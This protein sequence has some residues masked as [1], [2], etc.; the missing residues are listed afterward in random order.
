MEGH[1]KN[2]CAKYSLIPHQPRMNAHIVNSV[3]F[4]LILTSLSDIVVVLSCLLVTIKC[5][6]E[7][8]IEMEQKIESLTDVINDC[9]LWHQLE[10]ALLGINTRI[11][12]LQRAALR[13][14][15]TPGSAPGSAFQ[16]PSLGES[17][18]QEETEEAEVTLVEAAIQTS[19]GGVSY[20]IFK[21]TY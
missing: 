13:A 12:S 14:S 11:D 16:Q 8:Q 5:L 9:V 2:W 17:G 3:A 6:L 19:T 20:H 4:P 1:F 10:E 15:S 7:F 18:E 21:I